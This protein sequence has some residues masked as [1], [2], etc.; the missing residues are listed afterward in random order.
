MHKDRGATFGEMLANGQALRRMMVLENRSVYDIVDI[1]RSWS[2]SLDST[3]VLRLTPPLHV[4]SK[5]KLENGDGAPDDS[6]R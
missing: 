6:S 1:P 4:S 5:S 3:G 2:A